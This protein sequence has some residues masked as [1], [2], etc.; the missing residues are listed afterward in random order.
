MRGLHL[1]ILLM[2]ALLLSTR[3]AHEQVL[4]AEGSEDGWFSLFDGKSLDGWKANENT[5]TFSVVDGD[6]V[7]HG[8]RSHLFYVGPVS[9]HDFKNFE[10]KAEVMTKPSSNSGIYFH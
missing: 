4:A 10:F 5:G 6:I 9:N 3:P 8:P 2:L 1:S 7:A